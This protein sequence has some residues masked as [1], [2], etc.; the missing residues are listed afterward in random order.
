MGGD[1]H[2]EESDFIGKEGRLLGGCEQKDDTGQS[3]DP[4]VSLFSSLSETFQL[5]LISWDKFLSFF[6]ILVYFLG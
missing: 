4:S 6:F 5:T 2:K 1:C 3:P